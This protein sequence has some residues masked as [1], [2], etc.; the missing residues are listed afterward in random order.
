MA[1]STEGHSTD[2]G[3]NAC[4]EQIKASTNC[5][6]AQIPTDLVQLKQE[7]LIEL[8]F[9]HKYN[10]A[11]WLA[12]V[13]WDQSNKELR[14]WVA[15]RVR[16]FSGDLQQVCFKVYRDFSA[17]VYNVRVFKALA[18]KLL[19]EGL[20]RQGPPD[21][22]ELSLARYNVEPNC[23]WIIA[24]ADTHTATSVA[25][26]ARDGWTRVGSWAQ[27]ALGAGN[28]PRMALSLLTAADALLED[29]RTWPSCVMHCAKWLDTLEDTSTSPDISL[30][31]LADL[32]YATHQEAT[33]QRE[34][35]SLRLEEAATGEEVRQ[36][37]NLVLN[38]KDGEAERRRQFVRELEKV[39][40]RDPR[41]YEIIRYWMDHGNEHG[42]QAEFAKQKGVTRQAV[43]KQWQAVK[44]KYPLANF[45]MYDPDKPV[46][47]GSN[48]KDDQA[49]EE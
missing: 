15:Y 9:G 38:Y 13:R 22:R 18:E 42:W 11:Q 30:A 2:T 31:D 3:K 25:D 5:A 12:D 8:L 45:G 43:N 14:E 41:A 6:G 33:T 23:Q 29:V 10:G 4:E 39:K 44:D 20:P 48:A 24:S 1:E 7:P 21:E 27:Q 47:D 37:G 17:L 49:D 28:N 32:I 34:Q 19:W 16:C 46:A 40:E 35:I 26:D 36:I